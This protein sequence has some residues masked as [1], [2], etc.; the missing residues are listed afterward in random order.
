[1]SSG[2]A[3]LNVP[4]RKELEVVSACLLMEEYFGSNLRP[5]VPTDEKFLNHLLL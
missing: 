2:E 5:G 4:K 3:N 1:M